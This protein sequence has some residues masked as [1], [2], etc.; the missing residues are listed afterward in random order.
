MECAKRG[1][2]MDAL[3]ADCPGCRQVRAPSARSSAVGPVVRNGI[4]P[5]ATDVALLC[6]ALIGGGLFL[7][8]IVYLGVRLVYTPS[9]RATLALSPGGSK[10]FAMEGNQAY[11]GTYSAGEATAT[12]ASTLPGFL[13]VSSVRASMIGKS[14]EDGFPTIPGIQTRYGHGVAGVTGTIAAD[15][16]AL[17]GKYTI[18]GTW[19]WGEKQEPFRLY[20]RIGK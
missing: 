17:P 5:S 13:H 14:K 16:S 3:D 19:R 7:A 20:V 4:R 8:G 6:V 10:Q 15:A 2:S 11:G 9:M 18:Q 12:V 1:Y